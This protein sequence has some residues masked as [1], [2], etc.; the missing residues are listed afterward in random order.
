MGGRVMGPGRAR[1]QAEE[2]APAK[3]KRTGNKKASSVSQS[4]RG[5]GKLRLSG[6]SQGR[7]RDS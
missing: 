1:V 5:T 3:A 6:F 4:S 7:G 2:K